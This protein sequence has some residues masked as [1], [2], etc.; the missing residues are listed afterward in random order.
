MILHCCIL[1]YRFRIYLLDTPLRSSYRC[2]GN[3]FHIVIILI[4]FIF[5]SLCPAIISAKHQKFQKQ[6]YN[7]RYYCI[8]NSLYNINIQ[9]KIETTSQN[10]EHINHAAHYNGNSP[11]IIKRTGT[12]QIHK[13]DHRHKS[14][15]CDP[16]SPILHHSVCQK[17]QLIC[18]KDIRI[19]QK[20]M[21]H[22]QKTDKI[23]NNY[24]A[25][26]RKCG[27]CTA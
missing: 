2:L 22:F 11:C 4:I 13:E 23:I 7:H 12:D 25:A 21:L 17:L 24:S 14:H 26:C 5:Q 20:L 9:S 1:F 3:S 15:H 27:N 19:L 10:Y 16:H 8:N 6:S 18:H